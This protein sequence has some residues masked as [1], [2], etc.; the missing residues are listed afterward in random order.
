MIVNWLNIIL[1]LKKEEY[2]VWASIAA[3]SPTSACL[4][5]TA[6]VEHQLPLEL[7]VF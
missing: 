4:L 1:N 3:L 6:A 5:M 2:I 7:T